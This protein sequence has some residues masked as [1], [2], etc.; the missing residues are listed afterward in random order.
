MSLEIVIYTCVAL[1][2]DEN[3]NGRPQLTP[4]ERRRRDRRT[5]RIALKRYQKSSFFYLYHS[6]DDQAL[7]NCCAVDHEVFLSLLDLFEP[8][9]NS[10]TLDKYNQIRK[11]QFTRSG[12]PI[13]RKRDID[14]T[15]ALGLVL[16]WFRTRGSVARA[17]SMAFGLTSTPMYRWLKFSRRILVYILHKHP[18]AKVSLPSEDELKTYVDA[19]GT[20][21][22]LLKAEKA[23][24]AMDG[25]KVPIQQ[26]SN[27][28]V[29]NQFYNGWTCSTYI[30]SVFVFAPDGR[31]RICLTN[32]PGS[33]HDSTMADYG[34]Y[35]KIEDLYDEFGVK[36]VVDSAFNVRD[37]DCLI[38][39]AQKDPIATDLDAAAH[40]VS[41]N[42][43]ATSLRQLSEWG[44]RMIQG[45][46]P[47][48]KD[49]MLYEEYG[50][51]RVIMQLMVLLYNF[52][53]STVGINEILNS[54]MSR[55]DGFY[56]H[57]ITTTANE[58]FD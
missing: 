51:R 30:N 11:V 10:Y 24:A 35:D 39:S 29:Q 46:F 27:W 49:R 40:G 15:G 12:K 13:G 3:N 48:L 33:W 34:V 55:T 32:A 57:N 41:L 37:K 28:L 23:W 44:M 58:I 47:R 9:F 22:P 5:P 7:L 52:Q 43:Q 25:L 19:I 8:V 56:S 53:T 54:F 17:T 42:R 36:V 14:A 26:S 4:E 45:Q 31:I 6:G 50:E 38:K 1:L 16:Y 18:L 21:Y 2:A 20:K